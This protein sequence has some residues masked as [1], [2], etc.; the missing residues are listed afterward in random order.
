MS[1][2]EKL[3]EKLKSNPQKIRFEE[4]DKVL[5]STGFTKRQPRRGSSHFTYT[6]NDIMITIPYK[7]PYIKSR[8]I[9][10][11]VDLLDKLD[12]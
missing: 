1:R 3:L 12:D 8:Y 4:V 9:K 11:V 2:R 5:L 10:E 6:L 7:K